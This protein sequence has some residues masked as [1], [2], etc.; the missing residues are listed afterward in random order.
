MPLACGVGTAE[1]IPGDSARWPYGPMQVG[2]RTAQ[3]PGMPTALCL[4]AN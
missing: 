4:T 1:R 3:Q 2:V